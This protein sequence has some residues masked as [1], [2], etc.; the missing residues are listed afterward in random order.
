[1]LVRHEADLAALRGN[2][3]VEAWEGEGVSR[4][5]SEPIGAEKTCNASRK[6]IH[7]S[8]IGLPDGGSGAFP[9]TLATEW[10]GSGRRA[11][12]DGS[13]SRQAQCLTLARSAPFLCMLLLVR[14]YMRKPIGHAELHLVAH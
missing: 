2:H 14:R 3:L 13:L 9:K 6:D 11:G 8:T 4:N 10:F 12:F 7:C 1:L 5:A